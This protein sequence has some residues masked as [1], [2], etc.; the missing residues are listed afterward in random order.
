MCP[1]LIS[2]DLSRRR[3]ST[4]ASPDR[5]LSLGDPAALLPDDDADDTGVSGGGARDEAEATRRAVPM[6]GVPRGD[7]GIDSGGGGG[8]WCAR[9]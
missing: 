9:R 3:R 1:L 2:G 6:R 4:A 5:S 8:S 7:A